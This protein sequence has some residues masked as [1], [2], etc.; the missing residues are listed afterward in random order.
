MLGRAKRQRSLFEAGHRQGHLLPVGSFYRFLNERGDEVAMDEDYTSCYCLENGRPSHPP[1]FMVKLMLLQSHD[2]VSEREAIDRATFDLR[3]KIALGLAAEE[4]CPAS[5]SALPLFR[6]RL[7]L[8]EKEAQPFLRSIQ[9]CVEAGF[10]AK[11][12]LVAIDSSPLYGRGAMKDT[13]NLLGDGIAQLLRVLAPAVGSTLEA[14]AVDLGLSRYFG[15]SIKASESVD[16]LDPD[17]RRAFL[18][19][20][21]R[22]GERLLAHT[23]VLDL[24][25]DARTAVD[26]ATDLLR[27]LI[28]QDIV[29]DDSDGKP[30]LKRGLTPDRTISVADPEM[31]V[32]HKSQSQSFKGFKAHLVAESE[33]VIV[34]ADVTSANMQDHQAALDLVHQAERNTQRAAPTA[35]ADGAYGSGAT[36]SAFEQEAR[37]L[38]AKLPRDHNRGL[39]T[40]HD[41]RVDL[42]NRTATCPAGHTVQMRDRRTENIFMWPAATCASCPLRSRCT[43][44]DATRGREL[45]LTL[46]E[47]LLQ[48][49]RAQLAQPEVRSLLRRRVVVEHAIAR[50][51]NLGARKLPFFGKAKARFFLLQK[52]AVAN[53][54][55]GVGRLHL[56]AVAFL[57][58]LLPR[59]PV[60]ETLPYA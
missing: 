33:G 20:L 32:G 46:H 39:F 40:K 23:A 31:R 25:P 6:V 24:S 14:L 34:A 4:P 21:V 60:P 17:A 38:I 52:A 45:T 13:Y 26:S 49:A 8:H 5:R 11:E 28:A 2:D 37:T 29:T 48:R 12:L 16:W 19:G 22:D 59:S 50:L 54:K 3:W 18:Q 57:A 43:S 30:A 55:L 56:R 15:S 36:R 44:R 42:S 53:L 47:E 7:I 58:R 27:K 10:L 35:L 51:M 41:F 9:T 1:S